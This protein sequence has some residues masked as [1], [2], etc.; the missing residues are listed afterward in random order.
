M[1][2]ISRFSLSL[3]PY[4]VIGPQQAFLKNYQS[5]LESAP[6]RQPSSQKAADGY[7]DTSPVDCME[8]DKP[9]DDAASRE[10]AQQVTAGMVRRGMSSHKVQ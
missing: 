5:M 10:L 6:T 8:L 1:I 9:N 7:L 4:S 3:A 2:T